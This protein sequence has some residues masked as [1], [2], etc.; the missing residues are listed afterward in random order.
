MSS[1]LIRILD[2]PKPWIYC[3]NIYGRFII[4]INE[5]IA[6]FNGLNHMEVIYS[7]PGIV[8]A[9]LAL[10]SASKLMRRYKRRYMTTIWVI[11]H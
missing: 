2:V 7:P 11:H 10:F 8:L 9:S 6:T 3:T 5:G 4:R 1:M